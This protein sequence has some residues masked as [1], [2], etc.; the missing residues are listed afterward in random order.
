VREIIPVESYLYLRLDTANGELWTAVNQVKLDVGATVTVYNVLPLEQF[1]S[2]TLKRT[3]ARIYF[4][5]LEPV[6]PPATS[7]ATATT[8][9]SDAP[10]AD[11]GVVAPAV[12]SGAH[13]IASLWTDKDRLTRTTVAVRGVVVKYNAGVMGK[14]WIHLQDGSGNSNAGT[15]DIAATTLEEATVGDTITVMGTVR[16]NVDVGAGYKYALLLENARIVGR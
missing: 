2:P 1:A 13:I 11:V 16:T 10:E 14:N 12:G 8:K 6:A 5:S 3:F 4:G 15:H 7:A 9:S